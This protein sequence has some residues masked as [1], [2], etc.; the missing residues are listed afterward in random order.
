[1]PSVR[2]LKSGTRNQA[3]QIQPPQFLLFSSPTPENLMGTGALANRS[4]K[5]GYCLVATQSLVEHRKESVLLNSSGISPSSLKRM[6]E[7]V[8]KRPRQDFSHVL[9]V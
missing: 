1:M 7:D 5:E 4:K 2:K 8:I 9:M 3:S 6:Q